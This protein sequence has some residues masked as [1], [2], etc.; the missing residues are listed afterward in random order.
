MASPTIGFIGL[1]AMG[2]GMATHLVR[3]GYTV[4]GYDVYTPTLQRFAAAGGT[5]A[6]SLADAVRE[7]KYVVVM[8]ASAVQA[9][10]ALFGDGKGKTGIVSGMFTFF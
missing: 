3:Q 9:Q 4:V 2:F 7:K 5:V 6:T 1:G 8:V 10:D